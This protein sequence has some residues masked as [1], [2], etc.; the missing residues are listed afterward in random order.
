MVAF[1]RCP[2]FAFFDLGGICIVATTICKEDVL[3]RGTGS[4]LHLGPLIS[5][6]LSFFVFCFCLCFLLCYW[7]GVE[8][9]V[10]YFC[11]KAW[12]STTLDFSPNLS[13]CVFSVVLALCMVHADQICACSCPVFFILHK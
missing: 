12:Y 5:L 11:D 13:F 7:Q 10:H 3:N 1:K 4:L 8:K 9:L 2:L 6:S